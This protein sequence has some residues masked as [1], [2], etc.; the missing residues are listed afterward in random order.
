MRTAVDGDRGRQTPAT[1]WIACQESRRQYPTY[2]QQAN[3]IAMMGGTWPSCMYTI[4]ADLGVHLLTFVKF[5]TAPRDSP[6]ELPDFRHLY[7]KFDIPSEYVSEILQSV[8]Q[9]FGMR[10]L[11]IASCSTHLRLIAFTSRTTGKISSPIHTYWSA[12]P[13]RPGINLLMTTPGKSWTLL[14]NQKRQVGHQ[15]FYSRIGY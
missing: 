9:T 11:G 12:W 1:N 4:L 3:W 10:R 7:D 13:S 8:T 2:P 15:L 6:R 14:G 5:S